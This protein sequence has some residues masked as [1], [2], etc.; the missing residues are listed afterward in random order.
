MQRILLL[1]STSKTGTSVV[2]VFS[3]DYEITGLNS[4]DCDVHKFGRVKEVIEKHKPDI[5]IN[6]VAKNGINP[7]EE[8]PAD[9]F[10]LNALY[11]R[12]LAELSN[13]FGYIFVHFSSDS[14][15]ANSNGDYITESVCPKP[16]NVY[17][18][19]KYNADCFIQQ[20][21]KKYYICRSSLMIGAVSK[22]LNKCNQFIENILYRI[23]QGEK[24]LRIAADV[25]FAPT[26]VKDMLI[27]LRGLI[28]TKREYGVY[29]MANSGKP[30]LYDIVK[31]IVDCL[32]VGVEVEK[33]SMKEFYPTM[34]RNTC[35]P[36]ISEK[37]G[38]MRY[39]KDAVREY[40]ELN[41]SKKMCEIE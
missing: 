21:A 18:M 6:C 3:K 16:M 27:E 41:W 22:P 24:K 25:I 13:E 17:S 4:K 39:W 37:I 23:Q 31:F 10:I 20:I 19:T 9:A 15:F 2:D 8:D 12:L 14:I 33:T 11:P 36:M 29:H 40:L 26:C 32:D 30:S 5:L 7:C 38:S 34:R 28:E 1:G 35:Y